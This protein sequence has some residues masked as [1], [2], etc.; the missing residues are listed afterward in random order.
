VFVGVRVAWV[1][2]FELEK[3]MRVITK[4][5]IGALSLAGEYLCVG[6]NLPVRGLRAVDLET[7]IE[8]L[9]DLAVRCLGEAEAPTSDA[10]SH[11]VD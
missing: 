2:A 5:A 7:T 4:E 1:K 8:T 9:C 6:H 3:V 10:F 11:L